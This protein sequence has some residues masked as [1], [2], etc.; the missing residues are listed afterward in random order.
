MH[1][2]GYQGAAK[3]IDGAVHAY[4]ESNYKGDV[5]AILTRTEKSSNIYKL[6]QRNIYSPY[7]MRWH[8]NSAIK[9]LYQQTLMG[10]DGERTDPATGWQ[11]L[12]AGHRTYNP[13][14]RYFVSEDPVG[15]GYGFG[16]N[17]PIMNSDPTGN[18]PK[19]I[20]TAFKWLGYASSFG[21]NALHAKWAHIAGAVITT[22]L[23]IATLGAS[24]YTYGGSAIASAVTAGA[25]IA[26]S[27]PVAAAAVPANKGL[28]IAASVIGGIGMAAMAATAAVDIGLF[29]TLST[30]ASMAKAVMN[31]P[32][33][34]LKA[35]HMRMLSLFGIE[36]DRT[37]L[38]TEEDEATYMLYIMD[39]LRSITPN[40]LTRKGDNIFFRITTLERLRTIWSTLRPNGEGTPIECDFGCV[41]AAVNMTKKPININ[42]VYAFIKDK[43]HLVS[44]EFLFG[45]QGP[46]YA[47]AVDNYLTSYFSLLTSVTNEGNSLK[48]SSGTS[49]LE[50]V[51]QTPGEV[52]AVTITNHTQ[53]IHRMSDDN[54][55]TYDF[56]ERTV[57]YYVGTV[58][59][60]EDVL[61]SHLGA[62][63]EEDRSIPR[64]ILYSVVVAKG[65]RQSAFVFEE[66]S[67]DES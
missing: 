53:L 4:N 30:P 3:T 42:Y 57:T 37:S 20:G 28:N 11:F 65:I 43:M 1:I 61:F 63:E 25:T 5:A 18:V 47:T 45:A 27:V 33:I 31:I 39:L 67:D 23:T 50:Q 46:T 41:L 7:G 26:G 14:Q 29:F 19:W 44:C 32:G 59:C 52:H 17:N 56:R 58:R 16:S 40:I 10:F 24:A 48:F 36:T 2:I 51:I 6:S 64:D 15:G 60:I 8:N 55:A 9:P 22:G 54:W 66:A 21:L 49:S 34:E 38:F 62:G 12:G 35:L 13:G